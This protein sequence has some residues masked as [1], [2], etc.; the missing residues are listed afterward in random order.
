MAKH[1][2]QEESETSDEEGTDN[3]RRNDNGEVIPIVPPAQHDGTDTQTWV[4]GKNKWQP[5]I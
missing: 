1:A 5:Q 2:V 3:G 4:M